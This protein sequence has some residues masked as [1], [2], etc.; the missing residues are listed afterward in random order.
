[1]HNCHKFL[2]IFKFKKFYFDFIWRTI[3][4]INTFDSN[5]D[6]RL[7]VVAPFES[8]LWM[9]TQTVNFHQLFF[10]DKQQE[11]EYR[12]VISIDYCFIYRFVSSFWCCYHQSIWL[13]GD[14]SYLFPIS[15]ENYWKI[16]KTQSTW[17]RYC[18]TYYKLIVYTIFTMNKW[19][20]MN[21]FLFEM[22]FLMSHTTYVISNT[23]VCVSRAAVVK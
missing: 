1:M 9:I 13:F 20:G 12:H 6:L 14:F 2:F 8:R 18:R 4:T 15:Y 5:A 22:N 19:I 21:E 10:L 11:C 23:H 17:L 3:T 7:P 16:A